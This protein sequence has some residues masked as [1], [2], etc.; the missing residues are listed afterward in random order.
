MA[1]CIAHVFW[2]GKRVW[3]GLS[4]VKGLA[5]SCKTIGGW[6]SR[7]GNRDVHDLRYCKARRLAAWKELIGTQHYIQVCLAEL[8]HLFFLVFRI[9]DHAITHL[10]RC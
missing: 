4:L 6:Q 10:H 8:A 7:F 9:T 1:A 5:D 2:F 3:L